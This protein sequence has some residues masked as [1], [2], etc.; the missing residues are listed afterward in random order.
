MYVHYAISQTKTPFHEQSTNIKNRESGS[1]ISTI[2]RIYHSA[3]AIK[4]KKEQRELLLFWLID[5]LITM[6]YKGGISWWFFMFFSESS[7]TFLNYQP[8]QGNYRSIS[9]RELYNP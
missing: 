7:L 8:F 5:R 1:H 2:P 3:S 4:S 9:C 6:K